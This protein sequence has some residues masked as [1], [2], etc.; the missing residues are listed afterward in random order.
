[1]PL[2]RRQGE[3]GLHLEAIG[4]DSLKGMQHTVEARKNTQ[5]GVKI[6]KRALIHYLRG[7]VLVLNALVGDA[8][9][10][11]VVGEVATVYELVVVLSEA[12]AAAPE[13]LGFVVAELLEALLEH[14]R[15]REMARQAT[16]R[17]RP[18]HNVHLL[19]GR[20][21]KAE[22]H[23]YLRVFSV[24]V[25]DHSMKAVAR[26]RF[27]V[28]Y[29]RGS[30][31]FGVEKEAVMEKSKIKKVALRTVLLCL[32]SLAFVVVA[33]VVGVFAV[34]VMDV[35]DSS[36]VFSIV[37]EFAGALAALVCVMILGG[38][39]C[40]LTSREDLRTIWRLGW[41][42][43]VVTLGLLVFDMGS[44]ISE[45]Q[46][47][48]DN[49]PTLAAELVIFCA[50]IGFFEELMF[51]GIIF[52]GILA[53]SGGTHRGVVRAVLITSLLFGLAHVDFEEAS[54][55]FLSFV[56]AVL[57]TVQTGMY[58]FLLCV[59]V[60]RSRRLGGVS[61]YH[62]LDDLLVILPG[63]GLFGETFDTDYVSS[64]DDALPTIMF[65]LI[66]NPSVQDDVAYFKWS[67]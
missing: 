11:E 31:A 21:D 20:D 24:I 35:P 37:P 51:R 14:A 39:S 22:R 48:V 32:I 30:H 34:M 66:I 52:Q 27:G 17:G 28:P 29:Q 61:L 8:S 3:F 25:S 13:C 49:W 16:H 47:L 23:Q 26:T 60:L 44:Y 12:V 54:V 10:C 18:L 57:K 63:V 42:N 41:W 59:I 55:D 40:V 7:Q 46:P 65:Y 4:H 9:G 6:R 56:Q 1:M 15:L 64:G 62:G 58:S 36:L 43:I 5:V 67:V 50:C 2:S 38:S 45:G 19:G 53:V 33:E